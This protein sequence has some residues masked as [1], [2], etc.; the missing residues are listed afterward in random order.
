V[1]K[2]HDVL[3]IADEVICGFG[4]TGNWFGSETFGMK[5]DIM[6]MAKALSSGYIPIS[7]TVISEPI[8]D[9]LKKQSE[10]IGVFAHGFTYSG[11]PVPAAVAIENAENLRRARHPLAHQAN[12][13]GVSERAAALCRSPDRRRSARRRL[14]AAGTRR[15]QADQGTLRRQEGRRRAAGRAMPGKRLDRRVLG[16]DGIAL[17]SAAGH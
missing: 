11:H 13:A 3:L 16:G 12:D 1:L 4:R 14:V 8:F 6:T 5:P 7:A 15:Q 9:V 2:K 17:L 10:K